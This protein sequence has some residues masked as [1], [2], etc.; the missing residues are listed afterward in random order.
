M[1]E[2]ASDVLHVSKDRLDNLAVNDDD[3]QEMFSCLTK[4]ATTTTRS[5]LLASIISIINPTSKAA[6]IS[7]KETVLTI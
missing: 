7:V 2:F 4:H 3:I 6:L 5:V 1:A